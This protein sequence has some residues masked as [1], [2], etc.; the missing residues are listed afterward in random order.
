MGNINNRSFN[1]KYPG[2]RVELVKFL[3]EELKRLKKLGW[4]EYD[5]SNIA[6]M[7]T[8]HIINILEEN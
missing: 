8:K 1:E 7:F 3:R 2:K 4:P 5:V 6:A